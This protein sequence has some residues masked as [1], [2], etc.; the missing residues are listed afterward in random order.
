MTAHEFYIK[1]KSLEL[2][3]A[4][5]DAVVANKDVIIKLNQG[6][7]HLGRTFKD[8]NI[9][10]KYSDLY[11]K[12]KLKMSSYIAEVGT[13]D[14]YVTGQFYSEMDVI[15][16]NGEYII[17]SFDEKMKWLTKYDDIFGVNEDNLKQAQI[18]VTNTFLELITNQ[19]N[20]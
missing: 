16:E 6:Q 12:R 15:V 20:N 10:P 5:E 14:L 3:K 19:L 17:T 1:I 11:L 18:P 9:E 8:D 4:K 7:L 2:Q 13:P